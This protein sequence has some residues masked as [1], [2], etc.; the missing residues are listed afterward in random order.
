MANT[1]TTAALEPASSSSARGF[2]FGPGLLFALSMLGPASLV[3][4]VTIGASHGYELLWILPVILAFRFLWLN[5]SAKYVLVS[6]ETLLSGYTRCGRWMPWLVFVSLLI[7]RHLS[8]LSKIVLMGAAV[9][10]LLP[11]P[12]RSSAIVWSLLF[13]AAGLLLMMREVHTLE[14]I[15]RPLLAAMGAAVCVAAMLSHPHLSGILRGLFVPSISGQNGPYSSMLMVTALIGT[16]AGA[17]T[18]LSYSYFMLHKGWRGLSSLGRQRLDLFFSVGSIFLINA[19][20]Q[21]A[22]AGTLL[23]A[24]LVPR[25]AEH[26]VVVFSSTL[27]IAGRI[28]FAFGL[29]TVCFSG[30]VTGTTGN[31]L[32]ASDIW[33]ILGRRRNPEQ[34]Q[35]NAEPASA[36]RTVRL[37]LAA[38]WAIS[39]LYAL[40]LGVRPV[41][42]V[43]AASSLTLLL[44]PALGIALLVLMNSRKRLGP[45]RNGPFANLALSALVLASLYLSLRNALELLH[46]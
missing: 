9:D 22:A 41:S 3:E 46:R 45:Y 29:W 20:L 36:N 35:G 32:V 25:N 40:F 26:L 16:E 27:G 30:F 37:S 42:L 13:S 28:I 15:F 39:P 14:R 4:N 34:A 6:G 7:E 11:L 18:N 1:A 24:K 10:M 8:N 12:F 23:P 19:L 38:F 31:A 43:L 5:L 2:S 17:L 44:M 21:I 33:K